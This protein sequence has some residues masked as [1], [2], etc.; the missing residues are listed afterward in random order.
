M[1]DSDEDSN[2][3]SAPIKRGGGRRWFLDSWATICLSSRM[4]L[5]VVSEDSV[6]I[7]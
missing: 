2:E 5:N 4:L 3:H 1:P 7:E 6:P